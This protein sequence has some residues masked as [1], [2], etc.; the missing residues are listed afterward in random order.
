MRRASLV[1]QIIIQSKDLTHH[2][3]MEGER[4]DLA[5]IF[6]EEDSNAQKDITIANKAAIGM[7]VRIV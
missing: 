3:Q 1:V 5:V 7:V 6:V 4:E 2:F